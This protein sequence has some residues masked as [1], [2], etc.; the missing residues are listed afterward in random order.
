MLHSVTG[1]RMI[2]NTLGVL[3][4]IVLTILPF[5][6]ECNVDD[7]TIFYNIYI[8]DD[9]DLAL[10]IVKEQLEYRAKSIAHD[11]PLYYITIGKDIGELND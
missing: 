6:V 8:P 3:S 10:N 7:I 1:S 11:A 4:W 5:L 9:S 2:F